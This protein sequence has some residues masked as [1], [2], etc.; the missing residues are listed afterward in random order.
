MTTDVSFLAAF[1]AGVFSISSPC[2]LP[3]LP[4]YL[5]HIAGVSV[6][7]SKTTARPVVMRNAIAYVAGFSVVFIA[8]GAA[9]GA[10][11]AFANSLAF[12]SENRE[13]LVRIGG[14][15]LIILGLHQIGIYR[16]PFLYR[17]ARMS[18]DG[19]NPGTVGSSF[20]IGVGFGAGWS[21][22]MG[23]ILGAILT[24]AAGQGSIQRA[25]VLL[26][27]YSL[28]LAIP[29]LGA[30]FAIGTLPN[31]L[32]HINKHLRMVTTISGAVMLGV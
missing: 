5:A 14:A 28:G 23:P 15:L 26:T 10:A 6:G 8:F 16:I 31:I 3:L 32:R 30:A 25:T 29:F 24:M 18:L 13:W 7:Q 12:F 22:C 20:V 9:F 11:G 1:L 2:I 17:D 21:P 4:I 27:V 19:R